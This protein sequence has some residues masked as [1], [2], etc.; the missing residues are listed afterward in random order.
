MLG[1]AVIKTFL[2][3]GWHV[4]GTD[5]LAAGF[6]SAVP[7]GAAFVELRPL[8]TPEGDSRLAALVSAM[9]GGG[10]I[11]AVVL[12]HDVRRPEVEAAL[13]AALRASAAASRPW[14]IAVDDGG[15]SMGL[16]GGGSSG[17]ETS[18]ACTP[19][20]TNV[21]D[22]AA[23]AERAAKRWEQSDL[24]LLALVSISALRN[25]GSSCAAPGV[26]GLGMSPESPVLQR[27]A[28][29]PDAPSDGP[30]AVA[31]LAACAA[32]VGSALDPGSDGGFGFGHLL[33]VLLAAVSRWL[34][35]RGASL[36]GFL[37]TL[38]GEVCEGAA[39]RVI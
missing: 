34:P 26:L 35:D 36:F 28:A 12:G 21:S 5:D 27:A 24:P 8:G 31:A 32:R 4:T 14:V 9:G 19:Q 11:D 3:A 2:G 30:S 15:R 25:G 22:N 16:Y 29:A 17:L 13:A 33:H 23:V 6:R 7:P 37:Q 10:G 39:G 18:Q 1:S 20:L 38:L